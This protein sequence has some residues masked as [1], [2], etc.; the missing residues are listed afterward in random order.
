MY[1]QKAIYF[2]AFSVFAI[3]C[4]NFFVHFL[5]KFWIIFLL[6]VA[7]GISL[8]FYGIKKRKFATSFRRSNKN[9]NLDSGFA[10]DSV[11][12]WYNHRLSQKCNALDGRNLCSCLS[13][14]FRN[15]ALH[16]MF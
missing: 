16:F 12:Y 9:I 15:F 4:V 14:N 3:L 6:G 10:N 7:L 13:D 1:R 5:T 11:Q 8:L 2:I